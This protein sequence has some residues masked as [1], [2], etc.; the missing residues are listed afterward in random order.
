ML[1]EILLCVIRGQVSYSW[2]TTVSKTSLTWFLEIGSGN[3][4]GHLTECVRLV[5][6]RNDRVRDTPYNQVGIGLRQQL[7]IDKRANHFLVSRF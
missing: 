3:V 2:D 4:C 1:Y 6:E 7:G 5:H